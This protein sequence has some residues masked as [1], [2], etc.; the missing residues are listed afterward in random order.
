MRACV[1]VCVVHTDRA[2]VC[3]VHAECAYVCVM[4]GGT[5]A[6]VEVGNEGG[7]VGGEERLVFLKSRLKRSRPK[8]RSLAALTAL[9]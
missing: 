8:S 5:V 9:D 1:C 2:C 3:V 4:G 6:W 7:K